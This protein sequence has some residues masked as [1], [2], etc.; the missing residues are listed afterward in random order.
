MNK[1]NCIFISFIFFLWVNKG[2][3]QIKYYKPEDVFSTA[4]IS[5][6]PILLIFTTE[7]CQKCNT[8]QNLLNTDRELQSFI[9]LNFIPTVIQESSKNIPLLDRYLIQ[10]FP[11]VVIARPGGDL[12]YTFNDVQTKENI[13]ANLQEGTDKFIGYIQYKMDLDTLTTLE[14]FVKLSVDYMNFNLKDNIV[15]V[16]NEAMKYNPTLKKIIFEYNSSFLDYE[17]LYSLFLDDPVKFTN[18]DRLRDLMVYAYY[19]R[20]KKVLNKKN[21][22]DLILRFSNAGFNDLEETISYIRILVADK[23]IQTLLSQGSLLESE[24][25]PPDLIKDF[26]LKYPHCHDQDMVAKIIKH[27]VLQGGT[28]SFYT[29]LLAIAESESKKDPDNFM[30]HDIRSVCL[31]FLGYK[32]NA[33]FAVSKANELAF[34]AK[35]NY[36]PSLKA[37]SKN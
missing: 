21:T 15:G 35:Y 23:E 12:I 20:N 17:N 11:Q 30:L 8:L 4:K 10:N 34:K 28:K 37:I 13:L 5:E 36:K 27:Q 18:D 31:Y 6:M 7:N 33:M 25:L 2:Y 22:N 14:S 26:L 9:N 16:Y 29:K 1:L 24:L 32:E 3:T 19:N